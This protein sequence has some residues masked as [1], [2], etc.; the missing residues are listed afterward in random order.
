M[1][2]PRG[3]NDVQVI[4]SWT[5]LLVVVFGDAAVAAAAIWGVVKS[6]GTANAQLVSILTSAFTAI[7]AMTTAYFGIRAVSNTAQSAVERTGGREDQ[8]GG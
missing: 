7:G 3:R 5:G 8:D 6:T 4:R 2:R 1:P